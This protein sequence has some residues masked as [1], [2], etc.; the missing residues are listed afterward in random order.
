MG[1]TASTD[2]NSK[3]IELVM[4]AAAKLVTAAS[5]PVPTTRAQALS[6]VL[7][8]PAVSQPGSH[9]FQEIANAAA[10]EPDTA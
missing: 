6:R 8:C 7:L 9:R 4:G 3:T 10:L 5:L 2:S 1:P